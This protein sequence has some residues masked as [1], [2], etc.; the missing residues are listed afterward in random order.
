MIVRRNS[1]L[2]LRLRRSPADDADLSLPR[3]LGLDVED[4]DL[5]QRIDLDDVVPLRER[6]L[7][8]TPV[9]VATLAAVNLANKH[10]PLALL[11]HG[12]TLSL[13]YHGVVAES[14]NAAEHAGTLYRRV[15]SWLRHPVKRLEQEAGH[16]H[17]V[18]QAGESEVTPLIA[19]AGIILF[20]LPI[21]AIVL[22]LSFAAYFLAR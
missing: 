12:S 14:R 18:E 10:M 17:E 4:L 16:L 2:A 6:L 21:V 13:P 5:R 20:L 3:F 1:A 11:G 22:G 19:I 9:D 15:F 8:R 7:R